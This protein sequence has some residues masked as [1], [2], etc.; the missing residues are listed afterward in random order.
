MSA[1][2]T[3]KPEK[4]LAGLVIGAKFP[5]FHIASAPGENPAPAIASATL[6]A[7]PRLRSLRNVWLRRCV[8]TRILR[9]LPD[10]R[11]PEYHAAERVHSP[12]PLSIKPASGHLAAL[13]DGGQRKLPV[14]AGERRLSRCGQPTP[15]LRVLLDPGTPALNQNHQNDDKQYARDD[16]NNRVVSILLFLPTTICNRCPRLTGRRQICRATNSLQ[17][18]E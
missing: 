14:H 5:C 8:K 2:V 15:A 9:Y 12:V 4:A 6:S 11:N 7:A 3:S 13:E 18:P 17:P 16:P 10:R 1:A